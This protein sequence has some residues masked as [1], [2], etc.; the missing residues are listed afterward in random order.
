[1]YT[2]A[3]ARTTPWGLIDRKLGLEAWA[4]P[5]GT[6]IRI[7]VKARFKSPVKRKG[8]IEIYSSSRY[9]IVTGRVL[10]EP[11]SV[12]TAANGRA[13]RHGGDYGVLL[14]IGHKCPTM[15]TRRVRN[16]SGEYGSWHGA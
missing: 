6:G 4:P 12:E 5:S 8:I 1:M 15:E 7:F 13:A 14:T 10:E 9:F 16:S 11:K 2:R 3:H